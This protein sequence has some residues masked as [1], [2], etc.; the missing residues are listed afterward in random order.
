MLRALPLA[1]IALGIA[2]AALPAARPVAAA[3]RPPNIVIIFC[4]DLGYGDLGCYGH[5]TIQ[6]PRLDRMAAE[7]LRLT[8]FYTADSVCTPSRAGLLTGR[9]PIRTGMCSESRRVLFPDSA[10]GLP[11]SELTLAEQL[12]ALG[13]AT[14]AVGKWHLGHLNEYLPTRRGFDRY[15]GIPYSND[16][17]PG[18][19]PPRNTWPPLP[20]LRDERVIEEDPDQAQLTLRYTE[21]AIDFIRACGERPFFLYLPH[22]MPH[23][24]LYAAP[25]FAGASERGL[26][27]DVV[28]TIDYS[29][30][31]ILDVLAELG[32]AE[33]TLVVFTSDNGPWLLKRNDGGSA[34]LLREGKGSTWEG[35]F[36]VPAICWWPGSIAPGTSGELATTLDLWPTSV[37][38]A[39]GQPPPDLVLDGVDLSGLLLRGEPSLR[40]VVHYYRGRRLYALRQGPWKLHVLTQPGYGQPQPTVHDPPLLF[41]LGHDPSERTDVAAE[42]PEVVARLLD[43]IARHSAGIEAPP[44]QLDALIAGP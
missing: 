11:D 36:R 39:G 15:F 44:S 19:R 6:T 31:Q 9:L 1:A 29:T 33:H 16:M 8:A 32:L 14:A 3:E 41:H 42:H 4:D 43:E 26:Y 13:Y 20:L 34:G 23:V 24:P 12:R 5:P 2:A 25:P 40:E 28:E 37:A 17:L 7:G 18:P 10:G 38:L 35:G 30:G 22:T 21:E 27:G